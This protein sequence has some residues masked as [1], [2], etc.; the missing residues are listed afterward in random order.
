MSG[1]DQIINELKSLFFEEADEGL[2]VMESGLLQLDAGSD[3]PD[4]LN[5]IFRA[6]HSIKGGSG[7]FGFGELTAFTHCLE[8]LLDA[9]RSGQKEL[10]RDAI[11]VLLSSV[12]HLRSMLEAVKVGDPIDEAAT[13]TLQG[14]LETFLGP[15]DG[16]AET[17]APA[18][19]AGTTEAPSKAASAGSWQVSFEPAPEM[20][21]SG[22]VPYFLL[23]E[24]SE[25][26]EVKLSPDLSKVPE[27]GTF[28]PEHIFIR[29]DIEL[30]SECSQDDIEEIFSWV[31]DECALT[32]S[33]SAQQEAQPAPQPAAPVASSTPAPAVAAPAPQAAQPA[34]APE[35]KAP[36]KVSANSSR[37]AKKSKAKGGA[38]GS[39]RV[40]IDKVDALI[41]L[42][43]EL[44]ITQSMLGQ[45]EKEYDLSRIEK[46]RDGLTQLERNTRELQESVMAIR[47]LPIS[48]S[49]NRF[50]RLVR[51]L[52][53]KL[54]KKV[55]LRLSGESTEL[56]KTV[57]EKIGDPLVH[58]VRNSLDHGLEPPEERREAGKAEEG[59]LHLEAFHQGGNIVIEISDD[60]RGLQASKIR[61]RAI[62]KGI[63]SADDSLSLED[64]H[65]LLF[66]PGF[67]TAE[68]ISDISGRGV[69]LDVVRRNIKELGGN[70]EVRSTEGK[71]TTFTIRLPLTLAILD[72]Q[73]IQVGNQTYILP[74][75]SIVESLQV[76]SSQVSALAGGAEIYRL[77][78]QYIPVM[79][80]YNLFAVK[81]RTEDL[82]GGL[83]VV[84]EGDG[85][86]VGI[87]VDDLLNQQQVVI[88]SLD[89]NFRRVDGVSGAT[90]LGDGTVAL[91]LDVPGLIKFSRRKGP[92]AQ[93][94]GHGSAEAAA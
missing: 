49:F 53:Q 81:P 27:F 10:T 75:V 15:K 50:P 89:T 56:D 31:E 72:G 11:T 61:T 57:M 93:R 90:I 80:L 13:E 59:D 51:D 62:E 42:V 54:D 73:L 70:V 3:D 88:K 66:E 23:R 30:H 52:S 4:L 41:N 64:T 35:P 37:P 38:E 9:A 63:I 77:R 46:L 45:I 67:S 36:D 85:R 91:I 74:L 83:L 26:G 19:M 65:S 71:G 55:N 60:G 20:M 40:G 82:S 48:F 39:I 16:E 6:A 47:M 17:A 22:N 5:A 69:G 7:T 84:V 12:D 33:S 79:R 21:Q 87:L 29:W 25:L 92:V 44:V 32:I 86:Q 24:L 2:E 34:Q 58:L 68:A 18:E 14:Q 1:S 94:S 78:D 76:Q 43:G 8:E 28:D